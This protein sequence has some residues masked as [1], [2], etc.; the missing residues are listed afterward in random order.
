MREPPYRIAAF[1]IAPR[2]YSDRLRSGERRL[3]MVSSGVISQIKERL[4]R[5][6]EFRRALGQ[7]NALSDTDIADMRANRTEMIHR[8]YLNIYGD[9]NA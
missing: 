1:A 8:A 4:A 9:S 3:T 7:I 6:A 5:R 2:H